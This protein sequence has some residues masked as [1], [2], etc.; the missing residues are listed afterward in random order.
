MGLA[1]WVI[2]PGTSRKDVGYVSASIT[3]ISLSLYPISV[4]QPRSA[5]SLWT[6]KCKDD[7]G[8]QATSPGYSPKAP[9]PHTQR[10]IRCQKELAPLLGVLP[11]TAALDDKQED[12]NRESKDDMEVV[13][14]V[15][16]ERKAKKKKGRRVKPRIKVFS[17]K[18]AVGSALPE[19]G[20]LHVLDDAPDAVLI[21][22]CTC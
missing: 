9:P 22:I 3:L 1:A 14:G 16:M 17:A 4:M 8:R 21:F 15:A 2:L 11:T 5:T 6:G 10:Y 12:N 13:N 20:V 7:L 19:G 18:D